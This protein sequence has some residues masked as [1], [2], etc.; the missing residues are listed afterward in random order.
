MELKNITLE[1]FRERITIRLVHNLQENLIEIV[2]NADFATFLRCT[3]NNDETVNLLVNSI[4][5]LWTVSEMMDFIV[6]IAMEILE[7]NGTSIKKKPVHKTM[8]EYAEEIAAK[9]FESIEGVAE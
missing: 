4:G 6:D 5:V 8:N 7:K 3:Y 1:L 9:A 2:N